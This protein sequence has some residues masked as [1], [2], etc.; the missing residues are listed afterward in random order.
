MLQFSSNS[1]SSLQRESRLEWSRLD[2]R[3]LT[4]AITI[5][6]RSDPQV[7]F[8]VLRLTGCQLV[9]ALCPGWSVELI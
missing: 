9:L 6:G 8:S 7:A 3:R 1:R 5:A 4:I 2:W